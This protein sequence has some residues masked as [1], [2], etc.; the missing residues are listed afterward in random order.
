MYEGFNVQLVNNGIRPEKID[1]ERGVRQGY[2]L[3]SVTGDFPTCNR[4]GA[5]INN[6]E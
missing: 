2:I 1:I 3:I 6:K 4:L 5:E